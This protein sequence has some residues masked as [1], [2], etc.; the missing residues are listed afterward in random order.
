M[1]GKTGL[2][3]DTAKTYGSSIKTVTL[4]E[5]NELTFQINKERMY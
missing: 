5:F 4:K 3:I 2:I 1:E